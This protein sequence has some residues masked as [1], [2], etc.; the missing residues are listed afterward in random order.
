MRKKQ[1]FVLLIVLAFINVGVISL[2]LYG[3]AKS[4]NSG[5]RPLVEL[6][7]MDLTHENFAEKEARAH[8][9]EPIGEL[10]GLPAVIGDEFTFMV[11]DDGLGID[12]LE[13]FTVVL[14]GDHIL[15]L[16]TTEAY[17]SY[18][19]YYHFENPIGDDSEPW[20]RSEDLITY[21]QLEY[22]VDEFD[23]N[24]YPTMEGIYGIPASRPTDPLDPDYDDRNKI[25]TL[26]F[27]IKDDAYYD[28]AAESYIAGYFSLADN[29]YYQKNMMHIDSYDWTNRVGPGVARP[30]LYEG[31]FAHEYEH[32]IHADID[33]D[34]PSW[35]DEG[36]ADLAGYFCG[37]G[38]SSGHIAYYLVYHPS[39]ALTFWG[40]AL[41]DYG[42]SYLFQL[43]LYEKF[44]GAE[45]ITAL[46]AEP[47]NGIEGIEATLAFFGYTETFDE[48]FDAWTI[49]NYVDEPILGSMYGYDSIEFGTID[50]WGYSIRYALDNIWVGKHG[51]KAPIALLSPFGKPL[52]YTPTYFLFGGQPSIDVY[53]EGDILAGPGPYSGAW[54]WYSDVEAWAWRS[55]Y[56][57][58]LPIPAGGATLNFMTFF[59]IEGDWDYGYVEVFDQDTGEWYTLDAPGTVDYVAHAQDSPNTPSGR[60]PFD[61]EAANRWHAFTGESGGWIPVSMDLSDFGGHTI[62]LY[63]TSWQDGAYTL[64]GM[65]VDD[66]EITNGVLPFDDVELGPGSWLTTGW[67]IFEGFEVNNWQGTLIETFWEPTIRYPKGNSLLLHVRQLESITYM[68]MGTAPSLF[69][70][71]MV[72]SGWINGLDANPA[73]SRHSSVFIVSNRADHIL[74]ADY[75]VGFF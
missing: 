47:L 5:V 63:F 26:L 48:I 72:Q 9:V 75:V 27:N 62:N 28:P 22:L 10:I 64:Q 70:P 39:T 49:A 55:L 69:F 50:T 19:G 6:A 29:N 40:G 43:Y 8:E 32:M 35:V 59:E 16:I 41:E 38:H 45:F 36:L 56:Q 54:T 1:I 65:Y 17:E 7:L 12:Y 23:D 4:D 66:I 14:E 30:F 58:S 20:L 68:P 53:L 3:T 67:Y 46:V 44:G 71:W 73:S 21:D 42:A 33:A 60:E 2:A 11:S 61:Y 25:W 37:Y 24:I 74:P 18:D 15:I 52:P 13:D 57:E 31:V 51:F 34:E